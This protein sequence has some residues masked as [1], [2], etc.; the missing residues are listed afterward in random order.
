MYHVWLMILAATL[1]LFGGT[2]YSQESGS[3]HGSLAE[4]DRSSPTLCPISGQCSRS[5]I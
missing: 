5:S 2:A 3:E 4:I 1:I